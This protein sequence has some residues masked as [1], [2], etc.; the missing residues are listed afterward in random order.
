MSSSQKVWSLY[1]LCTNGDWK[2]GIVILNDSGL[3]VSNKIGLFRFTLNGQLFGSMNG[4][5]V[6]YIIACNM[7]V[8]LSL[9]SCIFLFV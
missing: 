6:V 2:Y 4:K 8:S 5:F 3:G 1:F 9:D 7:D